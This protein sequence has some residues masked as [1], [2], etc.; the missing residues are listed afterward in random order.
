VLQKFELKNLT[1]AEQEFAW[2]LYGVMHGI[3]YAI[4]SNNTRAQIRRKIEDT[5][6]ILDML[7]FVREYHDIIVPTVDFY[8]L[9]LERKDTPYISTMAQRW[10]LKLLGENV[11]QLLLSETEILAPVTNAVDEIMM[12]Y[13]AGL[14]SSSARLKDLQSLF[15]CDPAFEARVKGFL[16]AAKQC[17]KL[18]VRVFEP[19]GEEFRYAHPV[20]FS[21][22]KEY[23]ANLEAPNQEDIYRY[24]EDAKI[25]VTRLAEFGIIKPFEILQEKTSP[26]PMGL[27]A[28]W[29]RFETAL[30]TLS[31]LPSLLLG[32][33]GSVHTVDVPHHDQ[34]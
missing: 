16:R 17:L 6:Y 7:T 14:R 8:A 24:I 5:Q 18:E 31:R 1:D 15:K 13:D 10:V 30:D 25:I 33:G 3:S 21:E 19:T 34:L 29:K 4:S 11:D 9:Q 22:W 20:L 26:L 23:P 28:R 12:G 27:Q 32:E 2:A